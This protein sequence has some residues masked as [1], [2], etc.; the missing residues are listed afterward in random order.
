MPILR[1]NRVMRAAW[2]PAGR[3][4]LIYRY[5]AGSFFWG[6][7]ISVLGGTAL[8]ALGIAAGVG[9]CRRRG[10]PSRSSG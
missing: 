6:A 8:G 7:A 10:S 9:R 3:H 4:R 5:R 2:L 1:T